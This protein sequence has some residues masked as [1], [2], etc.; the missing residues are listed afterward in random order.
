MSLGVEYKD[1]LRHVAGH[2]LTLG[3]LTNYRKAYIA[4]L[5]ERE[6]LLTRGAG[7]GDRASVGGSASQVEEGSDSIG[8]PL[9]SPFADSRA[10]AIPRFGLPN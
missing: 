6:S 4:R 10:C 7:V 9:L 3:G 8:P 2:E 5:F 1:V